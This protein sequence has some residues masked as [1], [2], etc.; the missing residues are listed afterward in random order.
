MEFIESSAFAKARQR[1]LSTES[2]RALQN[3]LIE[4][5]TR[6]DYMPEPVGCSKH[7][8]LEKALANK[9]DYG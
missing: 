6:I 5:T 7:D 1:H 9:V 3:A 8:G 2:F 4:E